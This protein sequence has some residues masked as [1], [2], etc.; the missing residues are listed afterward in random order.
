MTIWPA[1][2][3]GGGGRRTAATCRFRSATCMTTMAMTARR[4][5]TSASFSWVTTLDPA[6]LT[7]PTQVKVRSYQSFAGQAQFEQ[8][9]DPTNDAERYE[10]LSVAEYDADVAPE[11]KAD[12]RFLVS[13]G[14]FQRLDADRTL[15]FQ[16][17]MVMGNG[18]EGMLANATEA[19]LT[20]YG[21]YLNLDSDP[22][23][24]VNGRDSKICQEDF[25]SVGGGA[26]PIFNFVPDYMDISCVSRI[27]CSLSPRSRSDDLILDANPNSPT[28]GKHCIYVNSD[29]CF[30]CFRQ[31]GEYCTPNNPN[32]LR[33][34]ELLGPGHHESGGE[35]RLHRD[36]R[37]RNV[38]H[39][40][41]GMAPPPPGMRLLPTDN[42]VAVFWN[43]QSEITT[44]VR[45]N[46]IDFE[47]YR[48]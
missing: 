7:A 37:Q 13:A 19:S 41:V 46:Q 31:N 2:S 16:A 5:A 4:L 34:L 1:T 30:E 24:G 11:K 17:A 44:D 12:F 29:N 47:S 14:P 23:T 22:E 43:N 38:V 42:A 21:N 28:Y 32:P 8:G 18:F 26:N 35:G 40:L 48:I 20:W 25:S 9:G 36:Q 33:T 6:G 3:R 15:R 45:T 10:L 27:S 39:W